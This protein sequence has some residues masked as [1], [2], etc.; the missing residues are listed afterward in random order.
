MTLIVTTGSREAILQVS[1]RRFTIVEDG[2]PV[3]VVTDEGNKELIVRTP[4]GSLAITF[5]GL[6]SL[7]GKR[8][9]DWIQDT[10]SETKS[11]EQGFDA[12]VS[13]VRLAADERFGELST[14]FDRRYPHCFVFAGFENGEPRLTVLTNCESPRFKPME[15][16]LR[17]RAFARCPASTRRMID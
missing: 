5:T 17:F 16:A 12:C 9:G 1:D 11:A 15:C 2:K 10:I 4:G 6:A 13:A 3:K 7:G 8:M 14:R